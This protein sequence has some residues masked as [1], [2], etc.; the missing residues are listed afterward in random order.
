MD[1]DRSL[2][3]NARFMAHVSR[4]MPPRLTDSSPALMLN[5]SLDARMGMPGV[6]PY[7]ACK[8]F[9]ISLTAAVARE[10]AAAGGRV[11]CLA[12]IPGDVR[13]RSNSIGLTPGSPDARQYAKVMLDRAPRAIARG[14][15]KCKPWWLHAVSTGILEMLSESVALRLLVAEFGKKKA[16]VANS[17]L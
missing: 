8:G 13:T 1:L 10:M 9:I 7:S 3:L 14:W 12:I 16:A 17:R 5:L 11:D 2:N 15:L 6:A 4:I